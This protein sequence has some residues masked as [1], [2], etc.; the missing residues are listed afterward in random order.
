MKHA[1]GWAGLGWVRVLFWA[2]PLRPNRPAAPD[3][4][5][6]VSPPELLRI[7]NVQSER[8]RHERAAWIFEAFEPKGGRSRNSNRRRHTTGRLGWDDGGGVKL[9]RKGDGG[10]SA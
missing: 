8:G 7:Q 9:R 3:A 6:V 2:Q 4:N 1:L 10:L 5:D